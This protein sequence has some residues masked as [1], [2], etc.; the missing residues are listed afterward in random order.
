MS[1]SDKNTKNPKNTLDA[2]KKI[3]KI[4]SLRGTPE[5]FDAWKKLEPFLR[6]RLSEVPQQ[7]LNLAKWV[8]SA[9]SL[10]LILDIIKILSGNLSTEEIAVRVVK[11]ANEKLGFGIAL[12]SIL[13]PKQGAFIRMNSV[14]I[15]DEEFEQLAKNP[16]KPEH[17]KKLMQK[18]FK[19][20]QSY[21][22]RWWHEEKDFLDDTSYTPPSEQSGEWNPKD[23]LLVPIT[24]EKNSLIGVLSVDNPPNGTVPDKSLLMSLEILAAQAGQ[25]IKEAWIYEK[26]ERRLAQMEI[27]YDISSR[28][29]AIKDEQ[30]FLKQVCD[31]LK[32]QSKYLWV[33]ILRKNIDTETLYMAAQK[34][35]EDIRFSGVRYKIGRDGGVAGSV[36]ASGQ[37][38]IIDDFSKARQ[39]YIPFHYKAKSQLAVPIRKRDKVLGVIVAE[40]EHVNSFSQEDR[41]F[42]RTLANQIAS[43]LSSLSITKMRN[44]ELRI[45]RALFE[46]GNMLSSILEP[47]RLLRKIMDILR[48]TF[49][50]TSAAIF[51]AEKENGEEYLILKAFAGRMDKELEEYKL[52][53]GAEG[54]V[55]FASSTG[56][57]INVPDVTK[58]PLY[59]S[60][61]KET[62]S[63]LAVPIKYHDKIL[64]VLDVESERANA[65]DEQ[66]EQLLELFASEISVALINAQLYEELESLAVTDGLTGLYNYRAFM[67]NLV[68]EVRRANRLQHKLALLFADIDFFKKY[69]DSFGHPQGDKVLQLFAE[70]IGENIRK[71]VDFAARY[72]GEEF[73]VILPETHL[74]EAKEVAERIR[75]VFSAQSEE[76]L[77]RPVTVSFGIAIFP[78]NGN[79]AE[80]L[81]KS[82]DEAMYSAKSQGRNRTC[83]A[84]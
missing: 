77:L 13:D 1:G 51:L 52:K 33:G 20:S 83:I 55:G 82:A 34:G 38:K 48:N 22:I 23:M 79:D 67:E 15:P 72:G 70:I 73:T 62:K 78:K 11:I 30:K 81:L 42:V 68:R 14:G 16:I 19:M 43:V 50:Y 59:I 75:E 4:I 37:F 32:N 76:K 66:D 57:P 60:G 64:G 39:Q 69:N 47:E 35:L 29:G 63:E 54:V 28:T 27:L 10:D 36:A 6:E 9:K 17:Y 71:E 5:H 25:S 53:K 18:K 7:F 41:R 74:E 46:I 65:F 12:I 58:F 84:K 49:S 8:D 45:R 26:T 44:E 56:T 24:D 40:S 21:L 31:T 80:T 61:F 2:L 3:G